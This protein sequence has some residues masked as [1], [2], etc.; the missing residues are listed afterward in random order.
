MV[1]RRERVADFEFRADVLEQLERELRAV[2]RQQV[3]CS[4]IAS[5][6]VGHKRF[7]DQ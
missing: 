2:I 3:R 6:L 7:G 1:R 4:T 5:D